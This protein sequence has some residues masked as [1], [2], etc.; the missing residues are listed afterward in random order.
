MRLSTVVPVYNAEKFLRR[1]LDSIVNQDVSD[2]EIICVND[3]ST[4]SSLSILKEYECNNSSI[5]VITQNNQ[6]AGIARNTGLEAA[7]GDYIHFMDADDCLYD[8]IYKSIMDYLAKNPDIDYLKL[9]AT[10]FSMGSDVLREKDY[11]SLN[12]LPTECFEK[13]MD[14]RENPELLILR[15]YRAPWGGIYKRE[16]LRNIRFSNLPCIEDQ[17]FYADVLLSAKNIW[18]YPEFAV[19]H[20]LDNNESIMGGVYDKFYA[21]PKSYNNIKESTKGVERSI[22][23]MILKNEL[24]GVLSA[25]LRQ[26]GEQLET[27][28]KLMDDFLENF[29]WDDVGRCSP[30]YMN[31][32]NSILTDG[33]V[34]LI[35]LKELVETLDNYE[36]I[37]LYGAGYYGEVMSKLLRHSVDIEAF[38]VTQKSENDQCNG[39]PIMS[40]DDLE[41][42]TGNEMAFFISTKSNYHVSIWKKLS[43]R[44]IKNIYSVRDDEFALLDKFCKT[45]IQL[46]IDL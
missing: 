41:K 32:A 27:A 34:L 23:E 5:K 17:Q 15:A 4:D 33:G 16:L 18:Y 30:K 44:G 11:Y 43:E 37:Y 7:T 22:R 9:R 10:V 21:F 35:S 12:Y 13:K 40:L 8:G 1:C 19:K 46:G 2:H 25:F 36:R 6:F 45:A 3:G 39:I 24:D 14:I 29:N 42:G 31:S 28:K 20:Q 26:S 38:V